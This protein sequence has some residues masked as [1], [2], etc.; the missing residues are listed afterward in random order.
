[1]G[2]RQGQDAPML[3]DHAIQYMTRDKWLQALSTYKERNS[4]ASCAR[5][6]RKHVRFRMDGWATLTFESPDKPG[7]QTACQGC[8]ILDVSEEGIAL[9]ASRKIPPDTAVSVELHVSGRIFWVSG[10]VVYHLGMAGSIR[11]GIQLQFDAADSQNKGGG[12]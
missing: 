11:I 9:R 7:A 8:Q 5:G 3:S 2:V 4:A 6:R 12:A 1:M 10:T